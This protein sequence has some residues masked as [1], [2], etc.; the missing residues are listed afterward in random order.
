MTKCSIDSY[1]LIYAF[2]YALGRMTGAPTDVRQA[3]LENKDKLSDWEKQK[4][5]SEIQQAEQEGRLGMDCDK[6]VWLQLKKELAPN[7]EKEIDTKN[8]VLNNRA[9][10]ILGNHIDFSVANDVYDWDVG[11]GNMGFGFTLAPV[12]KVKK[13]EPIDENSCFIFTDDPEITYLMTGNTHST[14]SM[15]KLE[16]NLPENDDK[17]LDFN[18]I[19]K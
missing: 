4:I 7:L 14:F 13:L 12:A 11:D 8:L 10:L 16:N 5:Y 15:K 17:P 1:I 3:I 6:Q 18:W 9:Y 19:G 2:R